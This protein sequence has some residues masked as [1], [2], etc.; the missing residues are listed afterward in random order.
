MARSR[1]AT[2]LERLL[3]GLKELSARGARIVVIS[4]FGRPKGGP[5]PEFSLQPVADKLEELLGR[6]VVFMPDCIGSDV[7]RAIAALAPGDIAVL[8][9]L[10][11]H[12]GEEKNDREFAAELADA[13]RPLRQRC[14]LGCAPRARLDRGRDPPAAVLRRTA[15]DGGDRRAA[16]RA[17]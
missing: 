17:R 15:D 12:K 10:R 1:D 5:D 6:P 11:F 2:R 4:H 9:N 3:P 8:E 14:V 13:R 7:E 16:R